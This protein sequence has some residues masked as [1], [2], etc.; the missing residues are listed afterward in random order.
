MK[1]LTAKQVSE[2][3]RV[4]PDTL[5]KMCRSR[6]IPHIRVSRTITIF[7]AKEIDAWIEKRHVAASP[8]TK[9]SPVSPNK[10]RSGAPRTGAKVETEPGSKESA[11]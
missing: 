10:Y 5:R 3:L 6:R 2:M 1:T 4:Q 9:N 8:F 7:D 11:A